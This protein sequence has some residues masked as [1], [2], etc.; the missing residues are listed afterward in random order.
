M[1]IHPFT[2]SVVIVFEQDF[3]RASKHLSVTPTIPNKLHIFQLSIAET[4]TSSIII[5]EN[6]FYKNI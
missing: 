3:E 4:M 5:S 2:S 1:P 6:S